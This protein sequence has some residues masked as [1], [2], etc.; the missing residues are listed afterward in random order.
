M[1]YHFDI[2]CELC[3]KEKYE[4]IYKKVPNQDLVEE[5]IFNMP[6]NYSIKGLDET[7]S[8]VVVDHWQHYLLNRSAF[9]FDDWYRKPLEHYKNSKTIKVQILGHKRKY[10]HCD[11][12]DPIYRKKADFIRILK[13][14]KTSHLKEDEEYT[15]DLV[16]VKAGA[17]H[18]YNIF[19][20]KEPMKVY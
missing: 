12:T 2:F 9:Y 18:E 19:E 7:D 15:L 4:R 3:R 10:V 1:Q 8:D 5:A 11:V 17:I 20:L 16:D 14:K 13:T 6:D